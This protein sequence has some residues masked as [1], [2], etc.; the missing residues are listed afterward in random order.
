MIVII[1]ILIRM[2]QPDKSPCSLPR[3][4]DGEHGQRAGQQR[5]GVRQGYLQVRES[6]LRADDTSAIQ[7]AGKGKSR[8]WSFVGISLSLA[9]QSSLLRGHVLKYVK[10]I[11]RWRIQDESGCLFHNPKKGKGGGGAPCC[12]FV[13]VQFALTRVLVIFVPRNRL[14]ASP[15]VAIGS[16]DMIYIVKVIWTV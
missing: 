5:I 15:L 1:F 16:L 9:S 3:N 8:L 12:S 6:S 11:Y 7:E 2:K 10:A 13:Q 4:R 14:T